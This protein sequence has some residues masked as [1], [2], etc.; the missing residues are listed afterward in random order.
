MDVVNLKNGA[1]LGRG[2]FEPGWK[3]SQDVKPIV[4]TET[5]EDS[6]VGYCLKGELVVRMDSG[7]ELRI[8][9]GDAFHIPPGHDAWVEG[10]ETCELLDLSGKNE[11]AIKKEK[12]RK[13]A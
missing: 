13:T 9:A 1:L 4:E 5:C 10:Q 12:L 8:S 6:H 11:Y 3:W 7:E 2:V